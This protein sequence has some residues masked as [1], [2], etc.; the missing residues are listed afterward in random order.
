MIECLICNKETKNTRT[1]G[2]HLKHE[3]TLTLEQYHN[4]YVKKGDEGLCVVCCKPTKYIK[5][6][7]YCRVCSNSCGQKHPDTI[8]KKKK[9]S[10]EKYGVEF[11][12]RAKSVRNK[13]ESTMLDKYGQAHWTNRDGCKATIQE[14][15]GVDYITQDPT[16]IEQIGISKEERH[17][18]KYYNNRPKQIATATKNGN[19]TPPQ[20]RDKFKLYKHLVW[21]ITEKNA[22]QT[23]TE[24]DLSKRGRCGT[25][26]AV[27]LDHM[28]S[29]VDG[30][31]KGILPYIMGSVFNIRLIPW[32]ENLD[33]KQNSSITLEELIKCI[34]T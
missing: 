7:E 14:K 30:F 12:I 33:K 26:G 28:L 32:K 34:N 5:W 25:E 23:F 9:I 29:L 19:I 17:G 2:W 31:N 27:Q 10:L 4:E 1:L 15:Y 6:G 22:K 3:H 20:D 16:F 21:K 13:A 8:A 18:D 24:E 11:H